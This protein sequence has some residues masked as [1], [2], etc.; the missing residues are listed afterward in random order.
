MIGFERLEKHERLVN[1]MADTLGVDLVEEV[2]RGNLAPSELRN[3]VFRCVGCDSADACADWLRAHPD[4]T[5]GAPEF[6]RNG[7]MFADLAARKGL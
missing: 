1:K 4:G 6:C 5:D 2:Q 7:K 3:R